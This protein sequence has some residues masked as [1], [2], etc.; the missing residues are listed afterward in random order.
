M[1][2]L[3][4]NLQM[5]AST[6]TATVSSD[7]GGVK[8]PATSSN[9]RTKGRKNGTGQNRPK[10]A[11]IEPNIPSSS[12]SAD[13]ATAHHPPGTMP[14]PPPPPPGFQMPTCLNG[15]NPF[16]IHYP[17]VPEFHLTPMGATPFYQP[18]LPPFPLY[19]PMG[20]DDTMAQY[21]MMFAPQNFLERPPPFYQ[22]TSAYANQ[23][24]P[25]NP[26]SAFGSVLRDVKQNGDS[27]TPNKLHIDINKL[28]TLTEL[29]NKKNIVPPSNQSK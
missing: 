23:N 11:N 21:P 18:T 8:P 13:N 14:N 17:P 16:F 20:Y 15:Q 9:R 26:T 22:M 5:S 27:T 29:Y 6:S 19:S 4:Q 2:Q 3:M 1:L 12:S 7:N 10:E 24:L 25:S 28:F